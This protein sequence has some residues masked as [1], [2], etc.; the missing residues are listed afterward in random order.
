MFI[1]FNFRFITWTRKITYKLRK[2]NE[3]IV[4]GK[5]KKIIFRVITQNF[6]VITRD[7]RDAKL[8]RYNAWLSRINK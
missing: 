5:K 1:F 7:F 4:V 6:R 3:L 2:P 8:S